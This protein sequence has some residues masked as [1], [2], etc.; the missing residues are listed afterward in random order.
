MG[1]EQRWR[2]MILAGGAL[3]AAAC[4]GSTTSMADG[5]A[6]SG[7]TMPSGSSSS[8][9]GCVGCNSGPD[10]CVYEGDAY[11]CGVGIPVEP[12]P[13]AEDGSAA[14]A[15]PAD[16][17]PSEAGAHDGSAPDAG[18]ADA[19]DEVPVVSFCCNA[20]PDP[21]CPIAYCSGGVGPD[22]SIYL[23]CEQSR[24]QC[25]SMNGLYERQPDGSLGCT[26]RSTA[27]H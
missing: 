6:A 19:T 14:D 13:S 15:A 22:A 17:S 9:G 26:P 4:S 5:D 16:A 27:G 10:P 20:N 12:S 25:E 3:A 11:W 2:E 18:P 23:T 1:W 8:S 24:T 21:C 7:S